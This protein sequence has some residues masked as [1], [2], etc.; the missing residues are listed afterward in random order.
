MDLAEK[1]VCQW[2][3]SEELGPL[4]F[5]RGEEHPFLGLK[6]AVEK[7]FSDKTA[8]RID[9]EIEKLI[10]AAQNRAEHILREN[11]EILEALANSLV[12]E[13][14]L[15]QERL[16]EFFAQWSVKLPDES[17]DIKQEGQSTDTS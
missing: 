4:S 2:G 12:E 5:S 16:K 3:M 1:M 13:E 10:N 11:R 14:T 17:V 9:L 6:L 7:T 8:W 15:D